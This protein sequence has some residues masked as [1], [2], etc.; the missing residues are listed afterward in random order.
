M[1]CLTNLDVRQFAMVQHGHKMKEIGYVWATCRQITII[2]ILFQMRTLGII[3]ALE[4]IEI[5][6]IFSIQ[7]TIISTIVCQILFH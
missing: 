2:L 5:T 4:G 3:F 1:P 6:R 7:K